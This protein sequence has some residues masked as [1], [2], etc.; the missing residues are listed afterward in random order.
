MS[1]AVHLPHFDCLASFD[2]VMRP[3]QGEDQRTLWGFYDQAEMQKGPWSFLR[4]II[5]SLRVNR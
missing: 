4:T 1:I 5:Q 3:D 2:I